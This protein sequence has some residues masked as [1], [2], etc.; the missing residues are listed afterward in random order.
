MPREPIFSMVF[1]A[2]GTTVPVSADVKPEPM[3]KGQKGFFSNLFSSSPKKPARPVIGRPRPLEA[4]PHTMMSESLELAYDRLRLHSDPQS[5]A[6]N[7]PQSRVNVVPN[8][9]QFM[10]MK[11]NLHELGLT[12]P[13]VLM[14]PQVAGSETVLSQLDR[15]PSPRLDMHFQRSLS[16]NLSCTSRHEPSRGSAILT[17]D[18]SVNVELPILNITYADVQFDPSPPSPTS[19]SSSGPSQVDLIEEIPITVPTTPNEP[20]AP[21]FVQGGSSTSNRGPPAPSSPSVANHPSQSRQNYPPPSALP[22]REPRTVHGDSSGVNRRFSITSVRPHQATGEPASLFPVDEGFFGRPKPPPPLKMIPKKGKKHQR[23]ETA[24]AAPSPPPVIITHERPLSR[25]L[26]A[27]S[28]STHQTPTRRAAVTEPA[29]LFP[30]PNTLVSNKP[31]PVLARSPSVPSHGSRSPDPGP[32]P[33]PSSIELGRPSLS[34]LQTQASNE[35]SLSQI[36]TQTTFSSH[37]TQS[38]ATSAPES[39][40]TWTPPSSWSGPS[41]AVSSRS[42][43]SSHSGKKAFPSMTRLRRPKSLSRSVASISESRSFYSCL[44][45]SSPI[46]TPSVTTTPGKGRATPIVQD[47]SDTTSVIVMQG[48]EGDWEA[49]ALKDV[50]PRL[51]RMKNSTLSN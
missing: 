46:L 36:N 40:P 39:P 47:K 33:L 25:A 10:S 38:S 48:H 35:C 22:A 14:Q 2:P 17:A 15:T 6:P 34:P 29:G 20:E 19:C 43:D 50:I 37:Q 28:R 32:P 12:T 45:N 3:A 27:N 51:R 23:A 49:A 11:D 16:R 31:V 30:I 9:P 44:N 1:P 26:S 24:V 7:L 5:L 41:S 4:L 13:V 21:P 42:G 18:H 8:V